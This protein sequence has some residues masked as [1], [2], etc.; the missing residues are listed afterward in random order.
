[1]VSQNSET[2]SEKKNP[3]TGHHRDPVESNPHTSFYYWKNNFKTISPYMYCAS[4]KIKTNEMG[5]AC[6]AYGGG[7]RRVHS[8]GRET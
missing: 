7:E 8:F 5:G 1:M 4:D 6:G 2:Y 3:L